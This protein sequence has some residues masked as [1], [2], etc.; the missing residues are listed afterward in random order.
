MSRMLYTDVRGKIA[1]GTTFNNAIRTDTIKVW[2]ISFMNSFH[3]FFR[4]SL[5]ACSRC[6]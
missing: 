1:I 6:N 2:S 5:I 4:G 3:L